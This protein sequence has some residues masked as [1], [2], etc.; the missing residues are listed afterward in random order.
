MSTT[1]TRSRC[2]TTRTS[3]RTRRSASRSTRWIGTSRQSWCRSRSRMSAPARPTL[4]CWMPTVRTG[5]I[6]TSG[7]SVLLFA[8]RWTRGRLRVEGWKRQETWTYSTVRGS[9]PPLS[10]CSAGESCES[11]CLHLGGF[12]GG[13]FFCRYAW[14]FWELRWS[15]EARMQ[16]L[17]LSSKKCI[18][19]DQ[20]EEDQA[21]L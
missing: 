16:E 13:F 21:R 4:A 6:A 14:R 7:V 1:T 2:W 8:W 10:G 3:T 15:E 12:A 20:K 9:S 11:G 19:P 17:F 5:R 18:E